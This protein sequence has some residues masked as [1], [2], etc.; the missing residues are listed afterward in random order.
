MARIGDRRNAHSIF[1]VSHEGKQYLEETGV[2][3]EIILRGIFKKKDGE[4]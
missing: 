2:D 3:G 1:V 4:A